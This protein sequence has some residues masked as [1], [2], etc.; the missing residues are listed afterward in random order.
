MQDCVLLRGCLVVKIAV[1]QRL[2][3]KVDTMS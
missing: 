1:R 3:V 2:A